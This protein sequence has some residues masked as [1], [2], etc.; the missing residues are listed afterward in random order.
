MNLAQESGGSSSGLANLL[1]FLVLLV[2]LYLLLIRPARSRA[3]QLAAVRAGLEPGLRVITTAGLHARVV[4][5]EGDTTVLEI[6]PGVHATFASAAVVRV[7]D[8]P[9]TDDATDAPSDDERPPA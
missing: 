9:V 3:K 2:G 8:E 6:A 1:F 7:L 5:I 4:A